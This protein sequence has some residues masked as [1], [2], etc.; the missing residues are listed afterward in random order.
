MLVV[1]FVPIDCDGNIRINNDGNICLFE[2]GEEK[3]DCPCDYPSCDCCP[4][5]Y[6]VTVPDLSGS[7]CDCLTTGSPPAKFQLAK[8]IILNPDLDFECISHWSSLNGAPP[9]G[10]GSAGGFTNDCTAKLGLQNGAAVISCSDCEW[11]LSI[12]IGTLGVDPYI[13]ISFDGTKKR[14]GHCP[15]AGTWTGTCVVR[16]G[17]LA[18]ESC[19]VTD[20]S[21]EVTEGTC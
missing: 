7:G 14:C 3:F 20:C 5:N 10:G 16:F 4:Q 17:M 15:P 1:Y 21:V 6:C 13:E 12:D 9:I 11:A 2:E 18:T 19:T 8:S